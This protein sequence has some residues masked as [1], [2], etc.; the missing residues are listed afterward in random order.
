MPG[1]VI[2]VK[3]EQSLF[4][5]QPEYALLLSWHIADELINN[6]S[7]KGFRGQYIVPLPTPHIRNR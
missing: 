3:D 1:T 5:Q 6:L 2:P 4:D 7:K